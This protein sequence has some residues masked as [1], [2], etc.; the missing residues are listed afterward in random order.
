[1]GLKKIV[2]IILF[3]VVFGVWFFS[4]LEMLIPITGRGTP[5]FPITIDVNVKTMFLTSGILLAATSFMM[6]LERL[7]TLSHVVSKL[8]R[9]H[10]NQSLKPV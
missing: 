1:M 4:L 5:A 7:G 10:K 9:H 6:G 2:P 3:S 8:N